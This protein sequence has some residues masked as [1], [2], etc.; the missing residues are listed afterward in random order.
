MTISALFHLCSPAFITIVNPSVYEDEHMFTV[1][2]KLV[3]NYV[4]YR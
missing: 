3:L 1:H 2:L 4:K